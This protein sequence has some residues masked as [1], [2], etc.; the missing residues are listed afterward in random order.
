MLERPDLPDDVGYRIARA[1]HKAEP[2]LAK[3][4]AQASE[5]TAKNTVAAVPSPSLLHPGVQKYLR[6]AGLLKP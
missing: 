6:E 2:A 1:L 5:T 4:L 3:R